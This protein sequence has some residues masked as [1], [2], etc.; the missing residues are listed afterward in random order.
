MSYYNEMH[1]T[2]L[3]V[4]TYWLPKVTKKRGVSTEEIFYDLDEAGIKYSEKGIA[5]YIKRACNMEGFYFN[6]E[7]ITK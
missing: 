2:K 4:R 5:K 6:G 3:R 1:K 7:E